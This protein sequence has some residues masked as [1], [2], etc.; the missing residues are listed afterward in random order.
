MSPRHSH[1]KPV[2]VEMKGKRSGR[3]KVGSKE[4]EKKYLACRPVELLMEKIE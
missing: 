2:G 4:G 3:R 1:E